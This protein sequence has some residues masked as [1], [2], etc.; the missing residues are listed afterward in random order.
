M[1]D[2]VAHKQK[3]S[4]Q[5]DNVRFYFFGVFGSRPFFIGLDPRS[6]LSLAQL[7]LSP[8][9]LVYVLHLNSVHAVKS[10]HQR[11]RIILQMLVITRKQLPQELPLRLRLRLDHVPSVVAVEEELPRLAVS[12]EL[13]EVEVAAQREHVVGFADSVVSPVCCVDERSCEIE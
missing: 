9:L 4:V 7:S 12:Y 8:H 3:H 2:C 1:R 13:D 10:C 11:G 6:I 5:Y